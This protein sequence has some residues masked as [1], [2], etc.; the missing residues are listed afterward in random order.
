LQLSEWYGNGNGTDEFGFS[1]L[2]GGHYAGG[3]FGN[4]GYHGNWWSASEDDNNYAYFWIMNY[5]M[6]DAHWISSVKSNLF[7]IRCLQD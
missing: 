4:V 3:K 7:S 6:E 2:S 1:A 5:D